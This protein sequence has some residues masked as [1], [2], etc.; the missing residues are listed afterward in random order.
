MAFTADEIAN[1]ANAALEFY[2]KGKPLASDIQEKPLYEKMIGSQKT[3]SGGKDNISVPV[4]LAHSIT[5]QGFTH[6]DTVGY[7]NPTNIRRAVYPWKELHAGIQI[8][9]SELKKDGIEVV[10]SLD[11]SETSENPGRDMHVLSGILDDK[12]EEMGE[13]WAR[14]FNEMLWLDGSTDPLKVPG[15]QALIT[16]TPTTGTVGGI[17]RSITANAKWRNRALVGANKIT[18]STS[19]QTLTKTL[20]S[21]VRQLQRYG[22]RPS[23]IL[24][25][26]GFIEK[27]EAEIHEKGTYT[28]QGFINKGKTDIGM[29]VISMAG[30]GD[31]LY[32]PTL[33]SLTSSRSNF[34]Y[35][36]D[37][38]HLK[39]WVMKGEDR[40]I[41][42]P[43]RPYDRYVLYR[44]M[45]WTGGL[46]MDQANCHG[47][48]EAA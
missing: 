45:T 34:C 27:L 26:S 22:G 10:N 17:D 18:S 41:Q 39:L 8:S 43:A 2:V 32:D 19:A 6:D 40:K 42:N 1:I 37:P 48:Y 15:I 33:D 20:R 25:G 4:K 12:L 9:F 44:G 30:V 13:G 3:F 24:C 36:I 11:G 47:V 21:E 23:L 16:D 35:M 7:Q 28:Q 46:V 5:I 31:F 38:K 14:S 29:P